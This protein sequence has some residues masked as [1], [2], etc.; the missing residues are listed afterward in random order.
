MCTLVSHTHVLV[1]LKRVVPIHTVPNISSRNSTL[2]SFRHCA[3]PPLSATVSIPV[4]L[5]TLETVSV[6]VN[7]GVVV[8]VRLLADALP[9]GLAEAWQ[10]SVW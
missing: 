6:E 10:A 1:K 8:V 7:K 5:D 4:R 2:F 3:A 9:V